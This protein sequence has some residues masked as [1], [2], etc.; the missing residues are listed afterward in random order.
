MKRHISITTMHSRKPCKLYLIETHTL[1]LVALTGLLFYH[2]FS[3][4]EFFFRLLFCLCLIP[5]CM[6][7]A[8]EILELPNL[9]RLQ[10]N[11]TLHEL[12][13]QKYILFSFFFLLQIFFVACCFESSTIWK[14]NKCPFHM[15]T[16][17]VF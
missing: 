10:K 15:Y 14:T 9:L 16:L 3:S 8:V 13:W 4:L 12:F 2:L 5:C 6:C 7:A 1:R 11:E 17:L